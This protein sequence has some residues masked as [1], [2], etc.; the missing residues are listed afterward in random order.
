LQ[1]DTDNSGS[2][3]WEEFNSYLSDP[4][5]QAYFTALELDVTQARALFKLM[6]VDGTNAVEITEFIDG[7]T[8]LRGSA[9]SIDVN[10]LLYENEQMISK[11][12]TY[13][14]K[15]EHIL[16]HIQKALGVEVKYKK[17][18]SG[19]K[20]HGRLSNAIHILDNHGR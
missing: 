10:M 18:T 9:K 16:E 5:V 8:R 2:L 1:A 13:M 14:E 12:T 15:T 20:G 19:S 17:Q 4:K 6:D 7:C 3:S 11:W